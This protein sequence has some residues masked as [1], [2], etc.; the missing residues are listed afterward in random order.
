M[1]GLDLTKYMKDKD[2][3]I[4]RIL[5]LIGSAIYFL[6][7]E[8]FLLINKD[9]FDPLSHRITISAIIL[10]IFILSFYSKFVKTNIVFFNYGLIY[11]V[12]I[13]QFHL[14]IYNNFSNEYFVGFIIILV[15]LNAYFKH[16]KHLILYGVLT[17]V[18]VLFSFYL[19]SELGSPKF[20]FFFSSTLTINIFLSIIYSL[21]IKIQKD[22][23]DFSLDLIESEEKFRQL[24][25]SAPDAMI[26][27]DE[28]GKILKINKR[29][30][31][32]FAY[33][34][35]ELLNEEIEKLLPSRLK[36]KDLKK[37]EEYF[38]NPKIR[39]MGVGIELF[40]LRKD[41]SEFPIEIAL[42]PIKQ[43]NGL[44]FTIAAI[45]DV[46]LRKNAEHELHQARE[47]L[48]NNEIKEKISLAKSE[49]ISKMSH[50]IRTPL[51]GISGFT[52]I[53]MEEEL[54]ENQ[55]KYVNSLKFSCDIMLTL[56]NDIL[57]FTKFESKKIELEEKEI[58]FK[59]LLDDIVYSF[60]NAIQEKELTIEI[61]NLSSC[62][63]LL[64]G[65]KNRISQIIM[66]LISN[67]IKFSPQKGKIIILLNVSNIDEQ[68][69]NFHIDVQDFGIGI[70]KNKQQIIFEPFIQGDNNI[71]KNFGGTGLGLAI[72]KH[73]IE[74]MKGKIELKS[75]LLKGSTFSIE[76]PLKK[77]KEKKEKE[78]ILEDKIDL[79]KKVNENF[80]I[81][82][83]ED[84]EI[85]QFLVKT[86]LNKR[87]YQV[88]IAGN[89]VEASVLLDKNKYHL[90]LMDLMMPVMD[91]YETAN[92]I[93]NS[94][95]L[96]TPIIVLTAD[97]KAKNM[98]FDEHQF[99][100]YLKKPFETDALI[101]IVNKY[102]IDHGTI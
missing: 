78:T 71:A 59:L 28:K 4:D 36:S 74:I 37:K 35:S 65:D 76:I 6:W 1:K 21:R 34:E 13:Q 100:G 42:S 48:K 92:Y 43:K 80:K 31:E 3:N 96:E 27:I 39:A 61:Q 14:I 93:R 79:T 2:L 82:L 62:S 45:R 89:G 11:L 86:I 66:N 18:L 29:T 88:D 69:C 58:N 22:L 97:V 7:G 55:R 38:K 5:L 46:T 50:E 10:A 40:G 23:K 70:A 77:V 41:G 44:N 73:L 17:V 83:V 9:F 91:G 19:R 75:E 25:E 64:I 63:N 67:A 51:N 53:L 15:S 30:E 49:F 8:I 32:F 95:K 33:S 12:T 52:N 24:M 72:V 102:N 57:D 20:A 16:I 85:N 47:L 60:Q 98:K 84:N 81:L 26:I 68:S 54:T 99:N 56:I 101:E 94:L 87:G 90:I